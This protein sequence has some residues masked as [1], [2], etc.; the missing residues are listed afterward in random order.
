MMRKNSDVQGGRTE[1]MK[2]RGPWYHCHLYLYVYQ[3][4]EIQPSIGSYHGES[5]KRYPK[6]WGA[7]PVSKFFSK[8]ACVLKA[9]RILRTGHRNSFFQFR[10]SKAKFFF[11]T[12]DDFLVLDGTVTI[13]THPRSIAFATNDDDNKVQSF[14]SSSSSLSLSL[15]RTHTHTHTLINIDPYSSQTAIDTERSC[16]LLCFFF[17]LLLR[18]CHF[19]S[20]IF[21]VDSHRR[22]KKHLFKKQKKD[23]TVSSLK[24][25]VYHLFFVVFLTTISLQYGT[26]SK[27]KKRQRNISKHELSRFFEREAFDFC[28]E[29]TAKRQGTRTA[30]RVTGKK[31]KPRPSGQ[32]HLWKS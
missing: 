9:R 7:A 26:Y 24:Y 19:P 22:T 8:L 12:G 28:Q 23:W 31:A 29:G 15:S 18:S 17:I 4:R 14:V 25:I 3:S 27:E 1:T 2:A 5:E 13:I 30:L 20:S 21:D 16:G 11:R 32:P 10:L 6:Q